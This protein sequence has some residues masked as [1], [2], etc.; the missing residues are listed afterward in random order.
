MNFTQTQEVANGI[1]TQTRRIAWLNELYTWDS[2]HQ[3]IKIYK[4]N[5]IADG[6]NGRW[7]W[8]IGSNYA[9]V[10]KMNHPG[11]YYDTD[12]GVVYGYGYSLLTDTIKANEFVIPLRIKVL[13]IHHEPLQSITQSDARKE[14]VDSVMQY[15]D[16]W[17]S[18][19][20]TGKRW[21]DNPFVW[22]I[23]FEVFNG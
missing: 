1:K 4:S 17:D 13:D 19:A 15:M 12:T 10:P 11:A 8:K 7:K 21:Q 6:D 2:G 14:G 9:V 23:D 16:L 20:P 3:G 22:I 18:L 5:P